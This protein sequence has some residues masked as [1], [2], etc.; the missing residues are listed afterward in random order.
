MSLVLVNHSYKRFTVVEFPSEE[1]SAGNIP[2]EI[3]PTAWLTEDRTQTHWPPSLL[4]I[5]Q[6]AQREAV[7]RENWTLHQVNILKYCGK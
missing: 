3:V 6:L 2:V 5:N 4:P 1:D 7:V